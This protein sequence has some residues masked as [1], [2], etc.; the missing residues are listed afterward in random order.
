MT[1]TSD[2]LFDRTDE[3]F[4]SE[5]TTCAAWVYRPRGAAGRDVPVVVMG[6]GLAGVRAVGL[7]AYA[8]RFAAAGYGVVVFDYRSFGDSGGEPRQMV[9]ARHQQQDFR[10]ALRF[11]RHLPG[12]D[13]DGVIAWGTSFGG[14]HVVTLAADGEP[15]AAII[16]QV[17]FLSGV[18]AMR[19][20]GLR[21]VARIAVPGIRDTLRGWAR[22]AP[23]YISSVGSPG[24]TAVMTS[25]DAQAGHERI[26]LSSGHAP[27]D[28]RVDV[29]ARFVL[30]IGTY[31]P[32]RGAQ[33]VTCPA[34]VQ[35]AEKDVVTPAE[36]SLHAARSMPDSTVRTYPGGHFDLYVDPLFPT[37]VADQIAF[38]R[39]RV[40]SPVTS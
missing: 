9:S 14:G 35:I 8:E 24:D 5:G 39:S 40:P 28:H 29:A 3:T 15:L 10:A 26:V 12:T 36:V 27:G 22:R 25:P 31:V 34:L 20:M 38:L 6:H 4:V 33:R 16:A 30:E 18:A 1:R 32:G 13:P 21:R 23:L 7:A 11:A 2:V 17:P 37:V 19:S